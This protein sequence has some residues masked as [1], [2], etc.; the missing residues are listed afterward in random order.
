MMR[1]KRTS[2]AS[3]VGKIDSSTSFFLVCAANVNRDAQ[4]SV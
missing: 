3:N 4:A 1:I 2:L